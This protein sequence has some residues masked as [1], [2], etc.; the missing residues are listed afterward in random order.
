MNVWRSQ[1]A[2]AA[3]RIYIHIRIEIELCRDT[4][5]VGVKMQNR[6]EST[7][8]KMKSLYHSHAVCRNQ[9]SSTVVQTIDAPLAVVWSVVRKFEDPQGYKQ[10][11]KACEMVS[12]DGGAGSVRELTVVSGMPAGRSTERLDRLDDE[13][14][15]MEYSIIG[16]DHK[17]VNYQAT[18]TVHEEDGGGGGGGTVVMESYVVDIPADSCGEDTCLFADTIIRY[19]LKSLANIIKKMAN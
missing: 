15:V 13:M 3:I 18:T 2:M 19:N 11:V 10:F 8:E 12:G 7:V 6:R 5:T 17:L 1:L 9:C 4:A 14:H 16:G